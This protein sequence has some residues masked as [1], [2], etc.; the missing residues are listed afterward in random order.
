MLFS[1]TEENREGQMHLLFWSSSCGMNFY[2]MWHYM[3]FYLFNKKFWLHLLLTAQ[4]FDKS[5]PKTLRKWRMDSLVTRKKFDQYDLPKTIGFSIIK[6]TVYFH[7]APF[8]SLCVRLFFLFPSLPFLVL[9]TTFWTSKAEF[10]QTAVL[11]HSLCSYLEHVCCLHWI[12]IRDNGFSITK[13]VYKKLNCC[14]N[15]SN[16]T[17]SELGKLCYDSWCKD[18]LRN[19]R[20]TELLSPC[21]GST[22]ASN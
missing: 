8:K 12:C 14:R 15:I 3:T 5:N 20:I 19:H 9:F 22:P 2:T 4:T 6:R 7:I 21:H 10:L 11:L 18:G 1:F 13:Y 17:V 16:S